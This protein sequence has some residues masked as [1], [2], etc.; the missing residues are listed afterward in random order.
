MVLHIA[1]YPA[2]EKIRKYFDQLTFPIDKPY[3]KIQFSIPKRYACEK[4]T[5]FDIEASGTQFHPKA[6]II[7]AGFLYKDKVEVY[8]AHLPFLIGQ[9]QRVV[10]NQL[11]YK[12]LPIVAYQSD[13]EYA[14]TKF[15]RESKIIF[16]K[17]L[18]KRIY[19]KGLWKNILQFGMGYNK[20]TDEPY[21]YR[22]K[23][24][25]CVDT[26]R[27]DYSG[28]YIPMLWFNWTND[29]NI[30]ALFEIIYHNILDLFRENYVRKG[31]TDKSHKKIIEPL[32]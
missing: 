19:R 31:Y 11:L 10:K 7:T 2:K 20:W 32:N 26:P 8:Q 15:G 14:F 13:F 3:I 25:H 27:N 12:P 5:I 22:L 28:R 17:F 9:F 4:G 30:N 29:L 24:V 16:D 18:Q 1:W 21:T 6:K 23:L